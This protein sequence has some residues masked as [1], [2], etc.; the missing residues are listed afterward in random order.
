[1]KDHDPMSE[2]KINICV[3]KR[4]AFQRERENGEI[5]CVSCSNPVIFVHECK[6]K[7]DGVTKTVENHG[8]AMDN[9]FGESETTRS[10][11]ENSIQPQI[12]FLFDGGIV[13]CF[14]YG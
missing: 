9:T 5:D 4:P 2:S 7:V 3:R 6:Y 12:D 11:Y 13:T 10:L 14:A 1:M 8:F